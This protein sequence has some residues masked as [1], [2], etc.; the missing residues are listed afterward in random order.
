MRAFIEGILIGRVTGYEVRAHGRKATLTVT[1]ESDADLVLALAEAVV[2]Y[3]CTCEIVEGD[4][5]TLIGT[6]R[7]ATEGCPVH[8]VDPPS[9]ADDG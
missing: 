8:P 5:V 3:T 1:V 9:E 6:T 4:G 2:A 7:I